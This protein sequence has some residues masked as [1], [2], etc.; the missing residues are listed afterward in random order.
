MSAVESAAIAYLLI[1]STG[2]DLSQHRYNA[3]I[4]VLR[5]RGLIDGDSRL[6]EHGRRRARLI[7]DFV[8]HLDL[9]CRRDRS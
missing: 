4:E 1:G 5:D 7:K 9:A 2:S 8:E 3:S 6:T